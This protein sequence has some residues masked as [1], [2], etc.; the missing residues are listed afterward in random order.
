MKTPY[1][2][3]EC[4]KCSA[5]LVQ[6]DEELVCE[7]CGAK[8]ELPESYKKRNKDFR[9]GTG[10]AN[11]NN[12]PQIP[13]QTNTT[14]VVS[15]DSSKINKG[16]TGCIVLLVVIVLAAIAGLI[17]NNNSKPAPK[18]L[19]EEEAFIK[20]INDESTPADYIF[21][22]SY[23]LGMV[24]DNV[25]SRNFALDYFFQNK[26]PDAINLDSKTNNLNVNNLIVR[27]NTG[28]DYPCEISPDFSSSP[29]E[30]GGTKQFNISCQEGIQ[31]E[32]KYLDVT[33]SMLHWG[34]H[35]FQIPIVSNPDPLKIKYL[36]NRY[37]N[38]ASRKFTVEVIFSSNVAQVISI[39]FN[40][41][42]VIDSLGNHYTPDDIS[43]GAFS[44]RG[45]QYY[46]EMV[47]N[48]SRAGFHLRF[49]QP[50]PDEANAITVIMTINGK[51]ITSTGSVDTVEGT[52]EFT[53][54][55]LD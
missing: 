27:D 12:P 32:V 52:I 43:D 2:L 54:E 45:N 23:N 22:T 35:A 48:N 29:V 44:I 4:V 24:L 49:D 42:N 13:D 25:D 34:E 19:T 10:Q 8:Y 38:D 36:L 30:P 7:Y 6:K 41:I 53:R 15:T 55:P 1:V 21:S 16:K 5:P 9:Q 26:T 39:D 40:D 47:D 37:G 31:P 51:T 14:N 50:F 20:R 17:I 18:V 11:G 46:S 33:V 3:K 28:R